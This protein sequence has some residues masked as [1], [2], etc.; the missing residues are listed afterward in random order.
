MHMKRFIAIAATLAIVAA[1]IWFL[2]RNKPTAAADPNN[3]Y[4]TYFNPNTEIQRVKT[5]IATLESRGLAGIQTDADTLRQ[6]LELYEAARYDESIALLKSFLGTHPENDTAQYYL[7]VS[8]M[9]QEHYARAIEMLYPLSRSEASSLR[10]DALWNLG[11]C[12]LKAENA[13]ED[14]RAAFTELS[15]DNSYPNHRGA[16][17]LLDQLFPK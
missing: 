17:A 14:A 15:N 13:R 10:N 6:A 12:Y 4:A 16:K 1:G 3:V 11:L 9:S 5:I 8:Y 2:S 7:G